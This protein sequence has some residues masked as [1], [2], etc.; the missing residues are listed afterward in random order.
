MIDVNS[1]RLNPIDVVVS[2]SIMFVCDIQ[3][4]LLLMIQ[5]ISLLT[6]DR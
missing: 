1:D 5:L 3:M 2:F 6:V 4:R